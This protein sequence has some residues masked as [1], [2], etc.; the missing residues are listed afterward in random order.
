[1]PPM[2][3]LS[4]PIL[5]AGGGIGGLTAALALLQR[6]FDVRVFEQAAELREVGAGLQLSPN[7]L[8]ALFGLGLEP[9]IRAVASE[10]SAKEVRLWSTGQTWK[11]FDLGA[12]AVQTYGYPYFM[13]YRPD[14]HAALANAVK[15]L[16]P[17]AIVLG[18]SVASVAQD[19]QG[20]SVTLADGRQVRGAALV[21]ADGVHS[22]TRA[23]LHGADRP[24]FSGCVAWRGVI[25]V[26]KLPADLRRPVGSNWVG[27]GAHV[28]HYPLRGGQLVNFVGIVERSDW[29]VESWTERGTHEECHRDFAGWHEDVHTM[30]EC[31][32]VPFKWALMGREPLAKWSQGR[33]TLLG[34]ACHPTLPFLA[35]GAVMAIEDGFVLAR[36]V[37][38]WPTDLAQAFV[39]YEQLRIERT[40]EIVRR[41]T[42]N[43]RRFH[44]P[45][46]ADATGAAAYVDREWSAAKVH[47]R[48]DWLFRYAVDQVEV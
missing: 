31:L 36:C 12:S 29:Q 22:K 15:A 46:L 21:G 35:Q 11:L 20:V 45:A 34:D 6:G 38:Q 41:S 26:E 30:I 5:I 16:S 33:A 37:D 42:E 44:N 9:A 39:R 10:P 40:S 17:Q 47:E 23:Q 3:K 14:L 32:E 2:S 13:I 28:I 8:R 4:E 27:P 18:A 43:G 19:D 24:V 7:A 25:P 1:M 48:Y